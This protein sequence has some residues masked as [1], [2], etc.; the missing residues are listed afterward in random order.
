MND[1]YLGG[2]HLNDVTIIYPV[3]EDGELVFFPAVREHWPMLAARCRGPCPVRQRN[4]SRR[5]SYSPCEDR[6]ARRDQ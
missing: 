6:R 4:L 5:N 3:F 1:P 2:T